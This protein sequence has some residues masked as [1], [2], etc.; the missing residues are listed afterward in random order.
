MYLGL[1]RGRFGNLVL[2]ALRQGG[3]RLHL[4]LLLQGLGGVPRTKGQRYVSLPNQELY[5][6]TYN[7]HN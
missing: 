4:G 6:S 7:S 5:N 2:A 3:L 1:L